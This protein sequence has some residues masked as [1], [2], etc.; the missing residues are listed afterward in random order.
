VDDVLT[1]LEA[2]TYLARHHLMPLNLIW[3]MVRWPD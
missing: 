3:V 1:W 2:A